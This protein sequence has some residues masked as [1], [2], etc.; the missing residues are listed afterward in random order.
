MIKKL[1]ILFFLFT[2]NVKAQIIM[3]N[4]T[5]NGN[6]LTGIARD[7]GIPYDSASRCASFRADCEWGVRVTYSSPPNSGYY[8]DRW[9]SGYVYTPTEGGY[10]SRTEMG[11]QTWI[12]RYGSAYPFSYTLPTNISDVSVCW[13]GKIVNGGFVSCARVWPRPPTPVCSGTSGTIDFG[14]LQESNYSG[15]NQSTTINISCS[16]AATIRFTSGS[17]VT[18]NN[19]TRATLTF[20][21]HPQGNSFAMQ[22]GNNTVRVNAT[23]S[24]TPSLGDFTGS[25][26]VI[27]DV[28]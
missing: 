10:A 17:N 20:N 22:A 27:L 16:A 7:N 14:S 19:G 1:P 26:T 6:Q 23:L 24:G 11:R 13:G 15:K 5:L 8:Q 18:L 21:G 3:E 4:A 9:I 28:L 2:A 12:S 25:S